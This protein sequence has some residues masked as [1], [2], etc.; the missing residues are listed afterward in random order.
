MSVRA[1]LDKVITYNSKGTYELDDDG[2]VVIS[3]PTGYKFRANTNSNLFPQNIDLTGVV[4]LSGDEDILKGEAPQEATPEPVTPLPETIT[5]PDKIVD[6][7]GVEFDPELHVVN[8]NGRPRMA[9]GK[10]FVKKK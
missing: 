7:R 10:Y 3:L 4:I 8:K 2:M 1:F 6:E 5:Q 9:M